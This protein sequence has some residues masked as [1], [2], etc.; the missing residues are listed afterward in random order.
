MQNAFV[1]HSCLVHDET[2]TQVP[3]IVFKKNFT[4]AHRPS[5]K[6]EPNFWLGKQMSD[7]LHFYVDIAWFS[8][9]L[10]DFRHF[11]KKKDFNWTQLQQKMLNFDD[12]LNHLRY[13]GDEYRRTCVYAD[14][15]AY[16]FSIYR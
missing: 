7:L 11:T 14:A 5:S 8:L 3:E 2:G 10:Y 4:I 6:Y 9:E 16:V 13:E 1:D 12:A 15:H